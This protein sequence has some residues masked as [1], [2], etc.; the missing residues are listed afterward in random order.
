MSAPFGFTSLEQSLRTGKHKNML[1][2][3]A[4]VQMDRKMFS[5]TGAQTFGPRCGG[6]LVWIRT[7]V[8]G[9]WRDR[10]TGKGNG[11]HGLKPSHGNAA[12][13]RDS[14]YFFTV[15]GS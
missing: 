5:A 8:E 10:K 9:M 14:V 7:M 6:L 13:T 15:E 4:M 11:I 1:E 3:W 12:Q 2:T